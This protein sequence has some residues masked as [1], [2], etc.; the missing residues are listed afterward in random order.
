MKK[1]VLHYVNFTNPISF[2]T[3]FPKSGPTFRRQL[4]NPQHKHHKDN[5]LQSLKLYCE[6]SYDVKCMIHR[7]DEHSKVARFE[8]GRAN[9]LQHGL[10]YG[11][12][13]MLYDMINTYEWVFRYN[14]HELCSSTKLL[15]FFDRYCFLVQFTTWISNHKRALTPPLWCWYTES[16]AGNSQGE[17]SAHFAIPSNTAIWISSDMSR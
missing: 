12:S 9:T 7:L 17:S 1:V 14:W 8:K 16:R 13:L 3:R 6:I 4:V 11:D 10:G 15:Y 5:Q 2:Q